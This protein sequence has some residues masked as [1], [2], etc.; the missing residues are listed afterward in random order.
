MDSIKI[1]K[2]LIKKNMSQ[3]KSRGIT[4][5]KLTLLQPCFYYYLTIKTSHELKRSL[6]FIIL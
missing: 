3:N 4:M 2:K 6:N 1:F 5:L